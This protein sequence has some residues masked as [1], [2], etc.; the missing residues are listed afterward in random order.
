M[1]P[2]PSPNCPSEWRWA[3]FQMGRLPK[4]EA[5]SFASHIEQCP[6][7]REK[8]KERKDSEGYLAQRNP[9]EMMLAQHTA[10]QTQRKKETP[11]PDA[12]SWFGWL[13]SRLAWG[14]ALVACIP[15]LIVWNRYAPSTP[16]SGLAP[17]KTGQTSSI[18]GQPKGKQPSWRMLHYHLGSRI[19]QW[20]PQGATLYPGDLVQFDYEFPKPLHA[21]IVSINQQGTI[22]VYVPLGAQKSHKLHKRKGT[23]PPTDSLELDNTL[24]LERI[25]M[26]AAERAFSKRQIVL[27]IRKAY[28]QAGNKLNQMP[29]PKGSWFVQSILINKRPRPLQKER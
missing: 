10:Q 6:F 16:A 18:N 20:T 19:S 25:F 8:Q 28:R 11:P 13:R 14:G 5:A 2:C 27:A 17:N 15:L 22:S 21:M 26:V 24:G 1:K 23:C 7:C 29:P 4:E 12:F 9:W 3:Q